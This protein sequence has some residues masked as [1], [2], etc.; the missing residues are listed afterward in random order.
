VFMRM[1]NAVRHAMMVGQ[2]IYRHTTF[3]R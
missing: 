3:L 1:T 2:S